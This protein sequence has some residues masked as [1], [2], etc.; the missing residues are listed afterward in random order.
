MRLLLVR[1]G[2]TEWNAA[3]RLQGQADIALSDR[4]RDQARRLRPVIEAL[5]PDRVVTSDLLRAAETFVDL[6]AVTLGVPRGER[7]VRRLAAVR[8]SA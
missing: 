1:H 4:G 8:E 2:E 3:R 6:V 5:R 7:T